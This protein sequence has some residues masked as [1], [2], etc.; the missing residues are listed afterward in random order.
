MEFYTD[1][2]CT[3]RV[4]KWTEADG[5]FTVNYSTT[6]AGESVIRIEMTAAGLDEINTSKTVYTAAD[7]VN[8]GYSDCTVKITYQAKMNSDDSVVFGDAG[9]PNE[10]VLVW[11]R[12]YHNYKKRRKGGRYVRKKEPRC[13]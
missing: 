4:A 9:N 2:A 7:M 8:S 13:R 6:D 11:R 10:V 5:K 12:T 3:K 1:S